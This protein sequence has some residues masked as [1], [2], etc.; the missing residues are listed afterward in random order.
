[1]ATK[2]LQP[3][4]AASSPNDRPLSTLS[5]SQNAE[6]SK[7]FFPRVVHLRLQDGSL[8]KFAPGVRDVPNSLHPTELE[9]LKRSGAKAVD[10]NVKEPV[11]APGMAT[12]GPA[13]G[14]ELA[15]AN[16]IG[17]KAL[18][19]SAENVSELALEQKEAIEAKQEA[20]A[21]PETPE[22]KAEKKT[23]ADAKLKADAD[24]KK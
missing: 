15:R 18:K 23:K 11:L 20:E 21:N 19:M 6:T 17:A 22:V 4:S 7:Y 16:A 3:V 8:L 14:Q 1:M 10:S 13:D 9:I 5:A 24:A 2:P 12:G